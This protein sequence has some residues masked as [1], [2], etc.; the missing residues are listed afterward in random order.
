MLELIFQGFVEW[1]YGLTLESWEYF[2]SVLLDIMSMD[3][4]YLRSHMPVVDVVM[5]SLLA[6]GWALLIGNLVFQAAKSMMSGLGFEGEDPKLLFLRTFV[7]SFLLAASPQICELCLD[8]TSRMINLM[9]VPD[10]VDIV[11]PDEAS[12]SGLAGSWLLVVICGVIIM[13]QSF[14]LIFE[15]AERY[16]ILA[17]LTMTSPLAFG[18][19]GSR[20]T[21]DVFSGWCRMYGSMCLLMVM[22]VIFIKM[23]LSVL[24]YYPSGLDVLPWMVLVISIVKVA[25]RID[26]IITRIGL[27]PAL[28]GDP[29][30]RTF[31]GALSYLV[32]RTAA[33][34]ITRSFGKPSDGY[35]HSSGPPPDGSGRP[36][37]P[38][39][40][41]GE[42]LSVGPGRN[43][44]ATMVGDAV[45]ASVAT[46]NSCQSTSQQYISG[47]RQ[48]D[49][50]PTPGLAAGS[51][52][53]LSFHSEQQTQNNL[54]AENATGSSWQNGQS[55]SPPSPDRRT[56]IPPGLRRAPTHIRTREA[57]A[58]S[59]GTTGTSPTVG[60]QGISTLKQ[61]HN[62][63]VSG[64][65]AAMHPAQS[66]LR[67]TGDTFSGSMVRAADQSH[68]ASPG[69]GLAH[70]T[71][72]G[73]ASVPSGLAG[74]PSGM[75]GPVEM[76]A[77]GVTVVGRSTR[78]PLGTESIVRV[79]PQ[80]PAASH[81]GTAETEKSLSDSQAPVQEARHSRNIPPA[82]VT[83]Q[84]SSEAPRS[85]AVR[86][87]T[88]QTPGKSM[89][90]GKRSAPP[91]MSSMAGT[92][93]ETPRRPQTQLTAQA[94]SRQQAKSFSADTP[95]S[96]RLS[97]VVSA[98]R[99]TP[100]ARNTSKK[101][102]GRNGGVSHG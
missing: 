63:A 58:S 24:S 79:Q 43:Y 33:S 51:V 14:K 83:A 37:G 87:K 100:P 17:V 22:H 75:T 35:G 13:F 16:L 20:N 19:G 88:R 64:E 72:R 73:R 61:P 56:S 82:S 85:S 96:K 91:V 40:V 7:F 25:K 71:Q 8:L 4:V 80:M 42:R 86:Q 3:F 21:S 65:T 77:S 38:S 45:S 55:G 95:D 47:A 98:Q 29:L 54:A 39:P 68:I 57:T 5:Q 36:T 97:S 92:A 50:R 53:T 89:V 70:V 93:P 41:V 74:H 27:N 94:R 28:T 101:P 30:G 62:A 102:T 60:R 69:A 90:A 44:S 81:P 23:L 32:V 11:F 34:Q 67:Q 66:V 15:M 2:S 99:K 12:F 76:A 26:G 9:E 31:P 49:R 84:L 59:A 46:Q 48:E 78:R 6:V 18:I 1:M 52:Q 10:A